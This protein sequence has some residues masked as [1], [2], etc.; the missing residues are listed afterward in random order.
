M[1]ACLA[2]GC[3][4]VRVGC[5]GVLVM[6]IVVCACAGVW[7]AGHCVMCHATCAEVHVCYCGVQEPA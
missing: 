7:G 4:C 5:V 3:A 2:G 1:P 6:E